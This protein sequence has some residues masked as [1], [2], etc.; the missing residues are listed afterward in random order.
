VTGGLYGKGMHGFILDEAELG[1]RVAVCLDA[2]QVDPLGWLDDIHY[3][4]DVK[5][6]RI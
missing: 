2:E 6:G 5:A 3:A 4:A 1:Y